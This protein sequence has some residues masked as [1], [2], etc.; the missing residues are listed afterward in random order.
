MYRPRE[1]PRGPARDQDITAEQL[2][3]YVQS[4]FGDRGGGDDGG[5]DFDEGAGA[6]QQQALLPTNADPKL[7]LVSADS[8][9]SGTPAAAGT[10]TDSRLWLVRDL[11]TA[12]ADSMGCVHQEPLLVIGADSIC[13]SGAQTGPPQGSTSCNNVW[14]RCMQQDA[15][16]HTNSAPELGLLSASSCWQVDVL[17]CFQ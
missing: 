13:G 10:R 4:R 15:Q 12:M 2:N 11:Q 8:R 16:L 1:A 6:V 3:E 17:S 7:W 9:V 14:G 5:E